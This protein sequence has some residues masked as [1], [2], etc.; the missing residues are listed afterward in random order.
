LQIVA[1]KQAELPDISD[2]V[3]GK[4]TLRQDRKQMAFRKQQSDF[5]LENLRLLK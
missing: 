2:K 5:G 3:F 1:V 4:K